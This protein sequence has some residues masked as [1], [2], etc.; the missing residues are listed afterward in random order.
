MKSRS[1]F[2]NAEE[3]NDYLVIHFSGVAMQGMLANDWQGYAKREDECDN[4]AYCAVNFAYSLVKQLVT[5]RYA[6]E[7]KESHSDQVI[8]IMNN[9]KETNRLSLES[10]L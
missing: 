8:E 6:A 4:L 7:R 2:K 3:Y 1:D 5:Q 9:D 10:K